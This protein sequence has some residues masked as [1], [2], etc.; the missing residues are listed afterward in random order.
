[1]RNL[2][3]L[4]DRMQ[5]FLNDKSLTLL[6]IF[7]QIPDTKDDQKYGF[8]LTPRSNINEACKVF[9]TEFL[10]DKNYAKVQQINEFLAIL[11]H[12]K[13]N[14]FTKALCKMEEKQ[15]KKT[16]TPAK[17]PKD[18]EINQLIIFIKQRIG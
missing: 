17:L 4:L 3:R 13:H 7:N 12:E 15:L 2:A 6:D 11:D 16:Q 1:M 18:K 9:K 14:L 8:K 5:D 10:V